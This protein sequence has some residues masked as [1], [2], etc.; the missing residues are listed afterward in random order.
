MDQSAG[1]SG[2]ECGIKS[3]FSEFTAGAGKYFKQTGKESSQGGS[4]GDRETKGEGRQAS[5]VGRSEGNGERGS[6]WGGERKGRSDKDQ[7]FFEKFS[8]A[9]RTTS[10]Q[11]SGRDEGE[12]GGSREFTRRSDIDSIDWACGGL[13][14]RVGVVEVE[15]HLPSFHSLLQNSN[16]D[17]SNLLQDSN[18]AYFGHGGQD[19][20]QVLPQD[21][22]QGFGCQDFDL[23]Q[24]LSDYSLPDQLLDPQFGQSA[25]QD[26]KELL[27]HELFPRP[28]AHAR[29]TQCGQSRDEEIPERGGTQREG[30]RGLEEPGVSLQPEKEKSKCKPDGGD[31]SGN[32]KPAFESGTSLD[33]L[34][35]VVYSRV[36]EGLP[37][38]LCGCMTY[39]INPN[40][41][42]C[43]LRQQACSGN[44]AV[45]SNEKAWQERV[46]NLA[47]KQVRRHPNQPMDFLH[48]G[49]IES[50]QPIASQVENALHTG[51]SKAGFLISHLPESMPFPITVEL[52]RQTLVYDARNPSKT[53]ITH[54][55]DSPVKL[56]VGDNADYKQLAL[57][58]CTGCH[59][60]YQSTK[61][62]NH[63]VS[64][65][66][67][68]KENINRYQRLKNLT[69]QFDK[70]KAEDTPDVARASR[71][72][73]VMQSILPGDPHGTGTPISLEL[74]QE[75]LEQC[76][77]QEKGSREKSYE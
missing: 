17:F 10:T 59:G 73:G 40:H 67:P 68:C 38:S 53:P 71:L 15:S 30:A 31:D 72:R 22:G 51:F 47:Q 43:L 26:G 60:W 77:D 1:P 14:N 65:S 74:R 4:L 57:L 62:L 8:G 58:S 54:Y 11:E 63:H 55:F 70:R 69:T 29:N 66:R 34:P 16:H 44:K 20:D 75:P 7:G 41:P 23:N 3:P 37:R 36:Q 35:D 13:S 45:V 49:L 46:W 39:P 52:P 61:G 27:P 56:L 42:G 76:P 6:Y 2:Q 24:V 25:N 64:R 28:A 19:F 21:Q 48:G 12:G 5:P 9:G 32:N 33:P 50:L 18:Q